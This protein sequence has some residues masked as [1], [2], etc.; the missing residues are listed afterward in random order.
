[1]VKPPD[2]ESGVLLKD[3]AGSS[4]VVRPNFERDMIK[5]RNIVLFI[6]DQLPFRRLWTNFV[7]TRN[8]WGG[9]HRRSHQRQDGNLKVMYNTKASAEKVANKMSE[10]HGKHF[11][12]YKCLFCDGYHLGKN[13][14]N[15]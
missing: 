7:V 1:M 11:S 4:P 8:A 10:K 15:K 14:G 2:C 9:L 5:I 6:Q 13:R 3:I 12:N